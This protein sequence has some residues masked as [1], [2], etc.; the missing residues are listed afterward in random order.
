MGCC[1]ATGDKKQTLLITNNYNFTFTNTASNKMISIPTNVDIPNYVN[2]TDSRDNQYKD[3]NTMSEKMKYTIATGKNT[4]ITEVVDNDINLNLNDLDDYN[5]VLIRRN[6]SKH[7]K[8]E[9]HQKSQLSKMTDIPKMK[10]ISLPNIEISDNLIRSRK[11]LILT[12]IEGKHLDTG[13]KLYINAGGLEGSERMAKDG[14]SL[15]GNRV[16]N[17]KESGILND[18]N[19]PSEEQLGEKHFEIRYFI[20]E[21]EYKIKDLYGSG[22]FIKVKNSLPLKHNAIF[23]VVNS[24]VLVRIPV[25]LN[26]TI[27]GSEKAKPSKSSI[28]FKFLYGEHMNREF[29]FD[30]ST[31]PVIILGRATNNFP[32][33][34]MKNSFIEFNDPNISRIQCTIYYH[35]EEA[36]WYITDSNGELESMNGTW[37]LADDYYTLEDKTTFRAGTTSFECSF[38]NPAKDEDD[39]ATDYG[40]EV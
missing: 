19:F 29:I 28:H 3:F 38:L 2:N 23:S 5:N 1:E 21:D 33:I 10:E 18:F 39:C 25:E 17:N 7:S 40:I 16:K 26:T 4:S 32:Q 12:I 31:S 37:L 27:E 6:I 20:D 9:S 8:K 22:L 35:S 30:S 13:T 36:C 11:K 15:F 24:H 34:S 14:V